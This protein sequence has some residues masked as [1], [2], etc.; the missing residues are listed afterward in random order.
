[1]RA[2]AIVPVKRFGAAKQRLSDALA[3]ADRAGLAEA[4]AADVLERIAACPSIERTIVVSGEPRIA[5]IALEAGAELIEDPVDAGH[6]DAAVLGVTAAGRAGARCVALLPGDCPLLDPAELER[7]LRQ[8]GEGSVA[9]IADRHGAGTNGLLLCP[10]DAIRPAF[11]PGSRDR[12]LRLAEQAGM[13]GSV[14]AIPS[15][16]LDL[17]TGEDL[18]VLRA[19]LSGD[20]AAAA[21]HTAAAL[22]EIGAGTAG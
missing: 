1:M 22:D 2:T 12:H 20:G 21:P 7:E 10:P 16:G 4:M 6:S 11:G 8:L 3:P 9:V 14:A 15:M 13:R 18:A 19:R 17:D 5:P